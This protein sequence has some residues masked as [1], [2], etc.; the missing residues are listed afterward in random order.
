MS[1]GDW[2]ESEFHMMSSQ[3]PV[4]NQ[5][6]KGSVQD[7]IQVPDK[8]SNAPRSSTAPL[9]GNP[10]GNLDEI[11][12]MDVQNI[13][14]GKS[15]S[16]FLKQLQKEDDA[17]YKKM[18]AQLEE[19]QTDKNDLTDSYNT[20]LEDDAGPSSH[21]QES[22]NRK[23]GRNDFYDYDMQGFHKA[24]PDAVLDKDTHY[25]DTWKK[26]NH[27]TFSNES[28][29][30]G[31][32][33]HEGGQWD[34]E[35][36]RYSFSPGRTNLKYHSTQDLIDYFQKYESKN[37]LILPSQFA[38]LGYQ[39]NPKV[40][41]KEREAEYEKK[42]PYSYTPGRG[43]LI[44]RLDPQYQAEID[45]RRSE[46]YNWSEVLTGLTIEEHIKSLRHPLTPF[47]EL[48]PDKFGRNSYKDKDSELSNQ[49][50]ARDIFE[51]K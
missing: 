44:D 21:L 1:D 17:K 51:K 19:K 15:H 41:N 29:Y 26:P 13:P 20:P 48:F 35:G 2:Y 43:G 22:F 40:K 38:D 9:R 25:P 39:N 14:E 32:D 11:T 27:P 7:P 10:R 33:N 3:K 5:E 31:K 46:P 30:H 16:E 8:F 42:G 49:A 36:G 34:L 23:Y 6:F 28:I 18:S 50:G 37:Q 47:R 45:D 4:I 24:Y 12:A